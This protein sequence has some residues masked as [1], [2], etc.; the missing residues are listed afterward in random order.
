MTQPPH[1]EPVASSPEELRE[2]VEQ[3]RTELGETVQALAAK[4]DVK[5][6]ARQKGAEVKERAAV[7]GGQ[8]KEQAA[9]KAGELKAKAA[10]VAHRARGRLPA[11]V[12]DEGAPG[13]RLV[14]DDRK[15]LWAV[16]AGAAVVVVWVVCR[17]TEG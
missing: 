13:A 8:L 12:G 9:L 2:Q 3:T 7:K 17:R 1:D 14:R 5:A 11:A 15:A 4:T 10:D 16:A 6:R